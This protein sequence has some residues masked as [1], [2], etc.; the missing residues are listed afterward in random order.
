MDAAL[1]R[2][3]ELLTSIATNTSNNAM[4]PAI[5]SILKSCLGVISNMNMNNTTDEEAMNDMNSELY[6]MMNKL[7]SLSKAI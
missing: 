1:G 5:V 4:L 7:D 2:I 6:S 3:I